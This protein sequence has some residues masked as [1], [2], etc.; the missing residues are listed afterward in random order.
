MRGPGTRFD[1]TVGWLLGVI[2]TIAAAACG[3]WASV[4]WWPR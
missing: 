2:L 3:R 1:V 4:S